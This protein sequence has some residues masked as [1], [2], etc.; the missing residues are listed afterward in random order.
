M[1]A[2]PARLK[3]RALLLASFALA[4]VPMPGLATPQQAA[5]AQ[6]AGCTFQLG[7]RMLHDQI[8]AIVGECL[9]DEHHNPDDGDGLQGTTNGLLV[10]RKADNWT[11]FTD[12]STTWI[13]GPDGLVSRPNSGPLFP[14]EAG[15]P[16]AS[17]GIEGDVVVG[18]TCPGPER[19]GQVCEQPYQATLTVLDQAGKTVTS[20]QTDAQGHFRVPLAPGTYTIHPEPPA[21]GP[22]PRAKDQRV[23][24]TAGQ[25]AP[26]SI[27]YDTGIR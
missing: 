9:E 11:A 21:S 22:L 1:M 10:W 12:G 23:T 3:R 20:F 5:A 16:A 4:L 15:A 19:V 14:W 17:S 7:F 6:A 27:R 8:P 18:P 24:V 13:N 26:V 25:F 2:M